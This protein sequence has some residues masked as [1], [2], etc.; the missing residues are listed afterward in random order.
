MGNLTLD[1]KE[2]KRGGFMKQKQKDLFSLRLR[3]VGGTM[4]GDQLRALADLAERFGRGYVHITTRQGV[5]VPFTHINDYDAIQQAVRAGG[6]LPGACGPRIRGVVAC[7]GDA[8]CEWALVPAQETAIEL[9][10]AFFGRSVAMKVKLGVSGCPNSCAKPQENDI[11][12]MGAVE[13]LHDDDRCTSCGICAEICPGGAITMQD[14]LPVIDRSNCLNEGN[15]ISSCP[16]NA[17]RAG[18]RGYHLFVGGKVGKR[19]RL[20]E[21]VAEFVPVADA[22][23]MVEKVLAIFAAAALPGE[24][25]GD[26]VSRLGAAEFSRLLADK[27]AQEEKEGVCWK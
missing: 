26:L 6:L 24:R 2:L 18:R 11:G 12:F 13:P 14:G 22:A 19:P 5:E 15:C 21:R 20:G 3:T 23:A 25:L 27:L 10:E 4:T 7:Q 17:W 16:S 9:D 1:L 8:L